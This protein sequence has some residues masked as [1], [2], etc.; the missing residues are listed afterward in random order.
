MPCRSPCWHPSEQQACLSKTAISKALSHLCL[1]H[2]F[3]GVAGRPCVC[4]FG[5]A[6]CLRCQHR[7]M[8]RTDP[9]HKQDWTGWHPARAL[10]PACGDGAG[11]PSRVHEQHVGLACNTTSD[12]A[13][14]TNHSFEPICSFSSMTSAF[15]NLRGPRLCRSFNHL[16]FSASENMLDSSSGSKNPSSRSFSLPS[17]LASLVKLATDPLAFCSVIGQQTGLL[18][19]GERTNAPQS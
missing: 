9:A 3:N 10:L 5:C 13:S 18:L 6:R 11:K 12:A 2:G 16:R 4:R 14:S 15:W 8:Q 7:R 17:P 19:L 1:L